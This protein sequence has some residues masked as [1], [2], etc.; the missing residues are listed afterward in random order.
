MDHR[1]G[2]SHLGS[3]SVSDA[4]G[5]RECLPRDESLGLRPLVRVER[6]PESQRPLEVRTA[7]I[8]LAL[9]DL[10]GALME[11]HPGISRAVR[12]RRR[13]LG[14]GLV[15]APQ[16]V[17]RPGDGV[18]AGVVGAGI[19][20]CLRLCQERVGGAIVIELEAQDDSVVDRALDLPELLDEANRRELLGCAR[21]FAGSGQEVA[22]Q[23]DR[24][25][26]RRDR[27]GRPEGCDRPLRPPS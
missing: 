13:H 26:L 20:R 6:R 15:E 11:D 5:L 18:V 27:G 25:R 4:R 19:E 10:D 1:T 12:H 9:A 23:P 16:A 14:R 2:R 8:G 21:R 17:E 24:L 22:Q 7:D 3:A